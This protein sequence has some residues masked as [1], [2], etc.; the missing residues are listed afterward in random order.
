MPMT[1]KVLLTKA[2]VTVVNKY[3]MLDEELWLEYRD[4]LLKHMSTYLQEPNKDILVDTIMTL[5]ALTKVH[6]DTF[7]DTCLTIVTDE[8]LSSVAHYDIGSVTYTD[9]SPYAEDVTEELLP[10]LIEE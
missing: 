9:P 3:D 7:L 2:I 10:F 4:E 8:R 6:V 1:E 5:S